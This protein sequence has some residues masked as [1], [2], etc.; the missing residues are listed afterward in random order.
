MLGT[1]ESWIS[2]RAVRRAAPVAAFSNKDPAPSR[3]DAKITWELSVDH[4][5]LGPHGSRKMRRYLKMLLWLVKAYRMFTRRRWQF[6]VSTVLAA[7]VG[8]AGAASPDSFR[9][10]ILGD[11]TGETQ[12]GVY[13]RVWQ[14][15]DN[16]FRR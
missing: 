15:A 3:S 6:F 12:P 8:I 7:L 5:G 4:E 9:F 11:R 14:R 2:K 13:E 1:L 10:V 16:V